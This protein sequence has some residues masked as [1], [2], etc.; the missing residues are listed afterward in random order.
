MLSIQ[1]TT[2]ELDVLRDKYLGLEMGECAKVEGIDQY[3]LNFGQVAG[4]WVILAV[5]TGL[6]CL[7]LVALFLGRHN[8]GIRDIALASL[9]DGADSRRRRHPGSKRWPSFASV[10]DGLA[11]SVTRG[12]PAAAW[13]AAAGAAQASGAAE[14]GRP[15]APRAAAGG[16]AGAAEARSE[17]ASERGGVPDGGTA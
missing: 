12:S 6:A 7:L 13:A 17:G 15:P 5:A 3:R 1:Q 9:D 8:K 14:N 16:S 11:K 10:R 4:L 2:D